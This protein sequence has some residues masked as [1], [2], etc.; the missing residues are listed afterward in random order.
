MRHFT[1]GA[2]TAVLLA[3]WC[4]DGGKA[5]GWFRGRQDA[6]PGASSACTPA[7]FSTLAARACALPGNRGPGPHI[8]RL[9]PV[10]GTPSPQ[11]GR[12]GRRPGVPCRLERGGEIV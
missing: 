10:V 8:S 5:R 11:H 12:M 6:L 3:E 1:R 7:R 4:W 2:G 9:Y